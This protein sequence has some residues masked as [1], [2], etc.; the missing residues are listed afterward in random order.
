MLMR[1]RSL[2]RSGGRREEGLVSSLTQAIQRRSV[3]TRSNGFARNELGQSGGRV[4]EDTARAVG[5]AV[6]AVSL[7]ILLIVCAALA[8]PIELRA[9][10]V[11]SHGGRAYLASSD[12]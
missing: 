7:A 9:K 2:P 10:V 12:P 4:M 6:A 1:I 8:E 11:W 5:R 3:R